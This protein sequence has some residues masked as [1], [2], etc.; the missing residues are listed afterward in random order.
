[1]YFALSICVVMFF[2][3]HDYLT[4]FVYSLINKKKQLGKACVLLWRAGVLVPGK[5]TVL[6]LSE[7]VFFLFC[8]S[9]MFCLLFPLW[10]LRSILS[11]CISISCVLSS[12]LI[13]CILPQV[14]SI[15]CLIIPHCLYY[16]S[17]SILVL[18]CQ[19]ILH[20]QKLFPAFWFYPF[21]VPLHSIKKCWVK[22][23]ANFIYTAGSLWDRTHVGLIWPSSSVRCF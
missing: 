5:N 21:C 10:F 8:Y 15:V 7:S 11:M 20:F 23:Q 18:P 9:L 13:N 14:F 4:F 16:L 6:I 3:L 2:L 12:H 17:P 1:M 22:K 19:I